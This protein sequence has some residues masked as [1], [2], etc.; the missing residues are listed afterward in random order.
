M[1]SCSPW[2]LIDW[3]MWITCTAKGPGNLCEDSQVHVKP[4]EEF[5]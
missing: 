4:S 5:C 2:G 1:L 3:G